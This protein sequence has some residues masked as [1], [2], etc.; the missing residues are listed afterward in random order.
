MKSWIKCLIGI[1]AWKQ[2][3]EITPLDYFPPP[4]YHKEII[5]ICDRCHK[6]QRWLPGYGGSELGSWEDVK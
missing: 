4:G 2:N 1:H 3:A 5:R 6:A